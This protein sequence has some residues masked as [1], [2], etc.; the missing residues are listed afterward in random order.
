MAEKTKEQLLE[1]LEALKAEKEALSADL[2]TAKAELTAAQTP[3][4]ESVN[5]DEHR[6]VKIKLFKDNDR[7]SQPYHVSVNDYNAVIQRGVTVEVPYFV[8]KHMEEIAAQDEAT[9]TMIGKL[10]TEWDS[11]SRGIL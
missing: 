8:A 7:Y 9:A 3:K 4:A 6:R 11:K 5:N 1:E 2:A 10:T